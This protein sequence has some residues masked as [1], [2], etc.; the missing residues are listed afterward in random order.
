MGFLAACP[1]RVPLLLRQIASTLSKVPHTGAN[2]TMT[3]VSYSSA[4]A[5]T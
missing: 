3:A 4:L 2:A 5:G 1:R